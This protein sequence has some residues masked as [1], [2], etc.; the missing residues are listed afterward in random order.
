MPVHEQNLPRPLSTVAIFG[1]G[2]I[3]GSIALTL[4]KRRPDWALRLWA[5][6]ASSAARAS[7]QFAS[8]STDAAAT[9][10]GADLCVL[11]TPL[12]AMPDLARQIAPELAEHASVTDAGSVKGPV[13]TALE[14]ILGPR[15]IG[16]HPMAGSEKAGL[17]A[18]RADLYEQAVC[19]LTP[20]PN[21]DASALNHVHAFW[22]TLGCRTVTLSPADHDDAVGRVS[23][24]PHAVAAALVHAITRH[25]TDPLA[26]AGG[27]Y[28]DSTRIAASQPAMWSEILLSNKA[29]LLAG[30]A[31]LTD[32]LA[33]LKTMI[34]SDDATGLEAY[35]RRA[36]DLR[37]TQ[38]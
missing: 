7:E 12:G 21:S 29:A 36:K 37:D 3:G 10:R 38:A 1:P 14:P 13:V 28:R 17:E 11:C 24:L 23:H 2:L 6:S 33:D 15:F 8:V 5:R 18:A 32:S 26:L 25:S 16:A 30:L 4:Q 35:L 22:E 9:A 34:L 31:D 20:T 27:G 19:I